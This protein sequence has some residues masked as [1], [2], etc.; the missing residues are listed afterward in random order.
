MIHHCRGGRPGVF[1]HGRGVAQAAAAAAAAAVTAAPP[2]NT[3]AT[4]AV[5][6]DSPPPATTAAAATASVN[7]AAAGEVAKGAA[8]PP[9]FS[10]ARRG[11]PLGHPPPAVAVKRRCGQRQGADRAAAARR[12]AGPARLPTMTDAFSAA[13]TEAAA[14]TAAAAAAGSRRGADWRP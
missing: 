4:A 2:H 1:N 13:V 5:C 14:A 7:M 3:P 8:V 12:T 6:S 9:L 10:F 11:R